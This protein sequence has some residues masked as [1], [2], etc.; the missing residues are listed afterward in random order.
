[1]NNIYQLKFYLNKINYMKKAFTFYEKIFKNFKFSKKIKP[2]KRKKR[3]LKILIAYFNK[4]IFRKKVKLNY[5]FL[6]KNK[7][8]IKNRYPRNRQWS[9]NIIYFGFWLNIL[10]VYFS[11]IFCYHYAFILNYFWW[12]VFFVVYIYSINLILS[13][14]TIRLK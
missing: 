9:K 2:L 12:L 10:L 1:M 5:F 14:N 13:L 11:Y 8:F 3:S 4:F 6:R 7:T